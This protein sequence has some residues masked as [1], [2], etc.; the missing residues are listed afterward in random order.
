MPMELL[1]RV[2]LFL[3][4]DAQK[5]APVIS[6]PDTQALRKALQ[7]PDGEQLLFLLLPWLGPDRHH[8]PAGL[9][10]TRRFIELRAALR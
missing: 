9:F 2:R 6:R 7:E 4:E 1:R 3:N 8:R 5:S 10:A